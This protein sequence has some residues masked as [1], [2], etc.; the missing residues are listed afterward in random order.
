[1]NPTN[2]NERGKLL[3]CHKSNLRILMNPTTHRGRLNEP[4]EPEGIRR[5]PRRALTNQ[6]EPDDTEGVPTRARQNK[7]LD[8]QGVPKSTQRT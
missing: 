1:M 3:G 6:T 2:P 8:P 4:N 5:P 7:S